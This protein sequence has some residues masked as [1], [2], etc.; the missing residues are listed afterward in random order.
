M[1]AFAKQV[2]FGLLALALMLS[3]VA[4]GGDPKDT[5]TTT[6]GEDVVTTV[7]GDVQSDATTT[8]NGDQPADSAT[9]TTTKVNTPTGGKTNLSWAQV[10][11]NMPAN[12]KGTTVRF[13]H[14]NESKSITDGDKVLAQFK[15][16]T[17][18][19]VKWEKAGYW[20]YATEVAAKQAAKD[21]PDVIRMRTVDPAIM[22][23]LQPIS[24]TG[25]NFNDAAWDANVMSAYSYKGKSYAVNLATTLMQQPDV[26]HYNK[27]L[28]KKYDLDDPYTLW[29]QG[30]WTW[31]KYVE[32]CTDFK[33]EAGDNYE[34]ISAKSWLTGANVLGADFV[35]YTVN[36]YVNTVTDTKLVQGAQN[37]IKMKKAGLLA[38]EL[39]Q[40]SAFN[41]GNILFFHDS[42]IGAR[43]NHFYHTSLKNSGTLGVVPLPQV[44]GQKT[45]YQLFDEYEAYAIPQGAK[46][47]A[48]V[49]YFLRYFLDSANYNENTFFADR[50][51]LEVYKHCMSQKTFFLSDVA[52]WVLTEDVGLH[53]MDVMIIQQAEAQVSTYL[54]GKKNEVE[55]AVRQAN[56]ALA[57]LG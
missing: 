36:G 23:M 11:A 39:F 43:K 19:T 26:L 52:D 33:D 21:A 20:T 53:L 37:Y 1:K 15:N 10:K 24:V 27:A 32:L 47:V 28:I 12:L 54:S 6:G 41:A 25:Y 18:I 44:D 8:V 46:N 38:P 55:S 5:T 4:C 57:L 31:K 16:E 9:T 7:G 49:P 2:L 29:K 51:I 35:K 45:Y 50:K 22:K 3:L 40:D 48:A 42:I 34:A 56:S 13:M 17:G 30:K 14:W